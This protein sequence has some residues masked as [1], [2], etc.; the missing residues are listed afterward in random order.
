MSTRI[1]SVSALAVVAAATCGCKRAAD[2]AGSSSVQQTHVQ[3]RT[4]STPASRLN[5]PNLGSVLL[6]APQSRNGHRVILS[7]KA[8]R[9]AD[10]KHA[11]AVGYCIYRG[12]KPNAPPTELVNQ[13]PFPET[14]CIDDSVENGKQ[15]YYVVRAISARGETSDASKPPASAKIPVTPPASF[16]KAGAPI[17]LCRESSGIKS[18]SQKIQ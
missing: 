17:P 10:A 14:Q 1:L 2:S 13:L 6:S 11:E 4:T 16:Q 15:Y 7:W 12:L 18:M 5:C 8:S 9:R 3:S